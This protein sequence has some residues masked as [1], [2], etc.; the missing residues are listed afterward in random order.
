MTMRDE[1]TMKRNA[2][3]RRFAAAKILAK[4]RT[5]IEGT[6]E[7]LIRGYQAM[8]ADGEREATAIEWSEAMMND[9]GREATAFN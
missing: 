8:A 2:E 9:R 1:G 4:N 3:G 5:V 7:D 6:D